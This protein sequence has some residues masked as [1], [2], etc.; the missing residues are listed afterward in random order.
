ML[1]VLNISHVGTAV[2]PKAMNISETA[3]ARRKEKRQARVLTTQEVLSLE[4]FLANEKNLVVDRFAAGCFL[5]ALFSRSRWSD[6]R[7]VYGHVADIV[8][9]EGKIMGYLEYKTRSHK[10]ARLVQKQGLPHAS[11]STSMEDREDTL[12]FGVPESSRTGRQTSGDFTEHPSTSSTHRRR[13][14]DKQIH[15]HF[16]GQKVAS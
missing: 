11:R 5:F 9:M 7:C 4:T 1:K 2:T 13:S 16:G 15:Q 14:V 6:L 12:G 10:T 3:N 8:E